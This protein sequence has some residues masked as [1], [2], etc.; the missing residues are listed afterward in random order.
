M[1][2]AFGR[3]AGL[4]EGQKEKRKRMGEGSERERKGGKGRVEKK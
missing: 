1:S 2:L 3:R 4:R